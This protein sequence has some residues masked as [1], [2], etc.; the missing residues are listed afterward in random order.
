MRMRII[1]RRVAQTKLTMGRMTMKR[2]VEGSKEGMEI[3]EKSCSR[4]KDAKGLKIAG[5]SNGG[6]STS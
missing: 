1:M 3:V 5:D 6:V 2:G 4:E